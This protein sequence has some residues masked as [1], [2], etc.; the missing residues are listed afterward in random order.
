VIQLSKEDAV[1]FTHA[2]KQLGEFDKELS[3]RLRKG[4]S[5]VM[6]SIKADMKRTLAEPTPA[7]HAAH[8]AKA[9]G[10]A[11]DK[12]TLKSGRLKGK[13]ASVRGHGVRKAIASSLTI[14]VQTTRKRDAQIGISAEMSKFAAIVGNK[15]APLLR[16]YNHK[17]WEHPTFGNKEAPVE[18]GGRPY[19]GHNIK[20]HETQLHRAVEEAMETALDAVAKHIND[21]R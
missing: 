7:A 14:K 1:K 2:M 9:R 5:D 10:K 11:K 20:K 18:Q 4:I 12:A 3:G 17:S 19:F 16:A 13:T 21:S 15:R 8:M 6:R